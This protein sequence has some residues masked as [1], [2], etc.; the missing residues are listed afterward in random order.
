[1]RL[2]EI[3]FAMKCSQQK[4][5]DQLCCSVKVYARYESGQRQPSIDVLIKLAEYFNVSVDYIIGRDVVVNS[6]ITDSEA[7]IVM[8]VRSADERARS[9]AMALLTIHRR[10]K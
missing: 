2:K 7:E 1:M 3:R 8:A 9:D 5:A 4:V 10:I 6:S